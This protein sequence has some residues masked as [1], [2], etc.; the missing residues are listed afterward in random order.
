MYRVL[1]SVLSVFALCGFR[2]VPPPLDGPV[3]LS[4]IDRDDDQALPQ[5]PHRGQQWVAGTPGHRYSVV[6]ENRSDTRK[7]VVLSVDGVNAITGQTASPAQSGYVLEPWQR[8]EISGWRKSNAE[9]AQ[10][11]FTAHPDSYAS[12]T[13]RP[14]D[15]GVIGIA[16]F[17]ERHRAPLYE[18][19]PL[20]APYPAPR[21]A[22][23][24]E[25]SARRAEAAA[26]TD[27]VTAESR[28]QRLGTGHG[29]R[30][31]SH[32]SATRFERATREPAQISQLRYDSRT[33]LVSLGIVPRQPQHRG[34]QPFPGSFVPDPP[35]RWR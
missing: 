28:R 31:W 35:P 27:A 10:F 17:D 32:A 12:R 21:A 26:A 18:V 15:V 3:L 8:S 14:D 30:E 13:G 4:V 24:A 9:V 34:P 5:Y 20:P 11:V 19:R 22:A 16:V 6:L 2:P 33:R 7:L 25:S 1:A 29:E 23:P